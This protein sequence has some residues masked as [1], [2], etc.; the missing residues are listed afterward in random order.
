MRR[1]VQDR[2]TH[3]GSIRKKKKDTVR[4]GWGEMD[5]AIDDDD[6]LSRSVDRQG[7]LWSDWMD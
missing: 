7:A 6:H 4:G 5:V 1:M 3:D 2:P